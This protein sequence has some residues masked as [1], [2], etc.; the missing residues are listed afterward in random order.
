MTSQRALLLAKIAQTFPSEDPAAVL[1]RLD[2]Y[3]TE[4]WERERERVQLAILYLCGGDLALVPDLITQS[5]R[6]YR[7]TLAAAEYRTEMLLSASEM[8]ALSR[9]ERRFI[10]DQDRERYLAWLTS[11]PEG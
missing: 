2:A 6:D 9:Y 10:R 8:A 3:G 1:L 5:K 7:D 11:I 4:S